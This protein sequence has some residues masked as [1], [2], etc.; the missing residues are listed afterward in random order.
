MNVT[1]QGKRVA[2]A[3]QRRAEELSHLVEKLGGV[4]LV[5]P[6]QGTVFSDPAETARQIRQAVDAGFDWAIFTTGMGT[7]ALFEAAAAHGLEADFLN[8]LR[9]ASIAARG[10][11]TVKALSQRGLR[12]VARD[13]DG[14]TRG[15]VRALAPFDLT[16]RRVIVQLHGDR[17]P[18]LMAF[19]AERQA[20]VTTLLPYRHVPPPPEQAQRL[21]DEILRGEVDAVAFTSAP[22][23]HF[24][25]DF[26][27]QQGQ[28]EALVEAFSGPVLAV[29]V[30]KITAEAL[31][32]EGVERV[33]TPEQERMGAMIIALAEHLST[34]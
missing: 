29:A 20:Q 14:T 3:A 23:V 24:L 5:R 25:F 10:Y 11:K 19:L 26:A 15:L 32:A 13:D 4:P 30:G 2:I 16:G 22:Q 7:N 1:L 18:H 17:A 8:A 27:R 34:A 33:V 12:P 31:H 28:Q 21:V 9:Q 6:M